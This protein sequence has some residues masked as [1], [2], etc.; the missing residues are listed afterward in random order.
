MHHLQDRLHVA[1]VLDTVQPNGELFLRWGGLVLGFVALDYV[2]RRL[3]VLE[4]VVS[5]FS[6]LVH[7]ELQQTHWFYFKRTIFTR[8][9]AFFFGWLLLLAVILIL[10]LGVM[11]LLLV[12]IFI[13]LLLLITVILILVRLLLLLLTVFLVLTLILHLGLRLVLALILL[14]RLWWVLILVRL[15]GLLRVRLLLISFVILV[16]VLERID[17]TE[18]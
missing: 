15:L 1:R 8:D 12:I 7:P 14:L 9:R 16:L 5:I 13:L 11:L 4:S 10:L 17:R 3:G 18:I 6:D 2:V